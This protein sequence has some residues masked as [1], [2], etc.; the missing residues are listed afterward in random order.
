[1]HVL[2][3]VFF[4]AVLN[5]QKTDE[6]GVVVKH[7]DPNYAGLTG[8]FTVDY[9]HVRLAIDAEGVPSSLEA[10]DGLPLNVVDALAEWRYQPWIGGP[11]AVNVTLTVRRKLDRMLEQSFH[12]T[13]GLIPEDLQEE[14]TAGAGMDSAMAV[15]LE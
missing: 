13:W 2:L 4:A 3:F 15:E 7:V 10:E 6:A 5:A 12:R 9:V 11:F 8:A 1:M 14:I